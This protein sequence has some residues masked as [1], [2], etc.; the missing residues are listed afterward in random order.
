MKVTVTVEAALYLAGLSF[1]AR[2]MKV[3]IVVE[4][5]FMPVT[6]NVS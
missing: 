4:D 5:L 1:F 3:L 6:N 2:T